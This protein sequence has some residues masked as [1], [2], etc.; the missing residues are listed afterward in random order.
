[1]PTLTSPADLA[2]RPFLL[3]RRTRNRVSDA[4]RAR[5][6]AWYVAA[7]AGGDRNPARTLADRFPESSYQTW[8][9]VLS[10][11]RTREPALLTP[12]PRRGVAGG[13]LTEYAE[14]LLGAFPELPADLQRV[15]EVEREVYPAEF[16]EQAFKR[17]PRR[18]WYSTD[19]E[20]EA[21]WD[22]WTDTA[23]EPLDIEYAP[24]TRSVRR[25]EVV[26]ATSE[27]AEDWWT[28]VAGR[29]RAG[30]DDGATG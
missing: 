30:Y 19:A 10:Q 27:L 7:V 6:C 1:M 8:A 9:N 21:A 16:E 5:L 23:S 18:S 24:V 3:S 20:F 17:E 12:A 29:E 2:A 22:E 28:R 15:Y 13:D 11:A 14:G 26:P 4:D 25:V